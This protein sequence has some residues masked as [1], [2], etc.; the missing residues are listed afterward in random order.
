MFAA[1]RR[2]RHAGRVRYPEPLRTM[3]SRLRHLFSFPL[4]AKELT[5]AAARPRTYRLRVI[6]AG[7]L[8]TVFGLMVPS[9][10]WSAGTSPLTILGAGHEMFETILWLQFT[11]IGLFLPGMMCGRITQEKERDS[12]V[13]LFLTDLRPWSIVLE[14]YLGGLVPM[15]SFLLLAMPLAALAYAFGGMTG[16]ELATGLYVLLLA[17]LQV[18]ALALMF[19]AWCRTTVSAFLCTYVGGAAFYG[20]PVLL[21]ETATDH[22][23]IRQ[24][25]HPQLER[26]FFLHIPPA[27]YELKSRDSFEAMVGSSVG[28][29]LS[30][31]LFLTLARVGLVR[32]AFTPPSN[33]FL[34]TFRRIDGWMHFANRLTG[35]AIVMQP[36]SRLPDAEPIAWRELSRKGLGQPQ[37]LVRI[38]LAVEI[39]VVAL[40]LAGALRL[41]GYSGQ[42]ELHSMLAAC[43]GTLAVLALS[44]QAANAVVSERVQQTLELLLTTPLT[45]R[46]IV[47]QKARALR[48]FMWVLAVPLLTIFGTECWIEHGRP[49]GFSKPDPT[50][51]YIVCAL[52]TVA[53]Y[54]PLVSW[55]SLWIGLKMRTRFKAIMAALAAVVGWAVGPLII[56]LLGERWL[57]P[58]LSTPNLEW[59]ALLSPL[60]VVGT[61]E[62][63]QLHQF[64]TGSDSSAWLPIVVNFAFYG[65]ALLAIRHRVLS[66]AERYLRR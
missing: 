48:R 55:L 53:I 38:L 50:A 42:S 31:V 26:F 29:L 17:A 23:A 51:A 62:Y 15:L 46:E 28:I 40:C 18:G 58:Y 52:L 54:L 35:G 65:L 10:A 1:S 24:L 27:L 12:L 44:V 2:E 4:L 64:R 9:W 3:T 25:I 61:N 30:I 14:K 19:S 32:R 45:A 33:F 56:L 60:S 5:E 8:Y 34:R 6:Y 7:L 43:V 41:D 57:R 66:R 39:P 13:L 37:Y 16:G 21:Y 63:S 47:L 36:G 49:G 20:L 11:G 59:F 22:P